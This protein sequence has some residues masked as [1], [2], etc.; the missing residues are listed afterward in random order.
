MEFI[1]NKIDTDI[2]RKIEEQTKANKV[3]SG[4]KIGEKKDLKDERNSDGNEFENEHKEKKEKK[5]I[6][7][8]GIR[9]EQKT[10]SV[11]A[12]KIEKIYEENSKGRVLDAKK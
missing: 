9:T 3:H 7:I 2:R 12:E 5:Y 11:K 6:T 10:M 4:K 8:D 1:V